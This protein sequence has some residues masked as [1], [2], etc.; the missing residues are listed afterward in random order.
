MLVS[1]G[2]VWVLG[3]LTS[4]AGWIAAIPLW[5]AVSLVACLLPNRQRWLTVAGGV[6]SLLAFAAIRHYWLGQSDPLPH[7]SASRMLL[8]YSAGMPLLLI[9]SLW[10]WQVVVE[11]DR[12]RLMAGELAVAQA[13]LRFAADLHDIQGHHLQVIALK[14]NWPNGFWIAIPR[15]LARTFMRLGSLPS[16]HSRKPVRWCPATEKRP[17]KTNWRMPAK[18]SRQPGPTVN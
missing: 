5:L 10:W 11:L 18:S 8:V 7:D 12:H 4:D 1:S 2:A 3:L 17:W 14:S 9:S 16:K 6:L 13:R 15:Q